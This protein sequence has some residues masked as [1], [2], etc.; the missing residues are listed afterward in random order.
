[1]KKTFIKELAESVVKYEGLSDKDLNWILSNLSRQ[2]LKL[3][4]RLLNN[5]IKSGNVTVYHAGNLDIQKENRI[6]TLFKDKKVH[7]KRDDE[8]L[9]AGIRFEYGDFILDYSISGILNRILNS[10]RES[11]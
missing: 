2:E 9:G 11:L 10:I 6:R 8:D 1:M 5:E 7:F 3:F 4:L